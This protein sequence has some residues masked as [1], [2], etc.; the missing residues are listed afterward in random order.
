[1]RRRSDLILVADLVVSLLVA[2]KPPFMSLPSWE[3]ISRAGEVWAAPRRP[4]KSDVALTLYRDA[5][6]WCP[7]CQR[8]WFFMEAKGLRYVT[9]KI[10]LQSDPAEPPKPAFY[11]R[12]VPSGSVPAVAIRDE[13]IPE[14]MDILYRLE[15]EFPEPVMLPKGEEVHAQKLCDHSMAFNTELCDWLHNTQPHLEEVFREE[16]VKRFR[17]LEDALAVRGGPFFLG[18]Q[19]SI[20]DAAYIGFLTRSAHNF[21]YFK[22][23]DISDPSTSPRLA[24]WFNAME[25]LPAYQHTKQDA[26]FEQ[27]IFQSHPERRAF[28]EPWMGLGQGKLVGEPDCRMQPEP[29]KTP[30]KAGGLSAL[31]AASN[32]SERREAVVR[33]LMRKHNGVTIS[34][35]TECHLQAMSAVLAGLMPPSEAVAAVGGSSALVEGPVRQLGELIRTPSDMSSAAAAQVL[36]ALALM[37]DAP[38]NASS[39]T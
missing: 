7:F 1:M 19:P 37:A 18:R 12:L 10:S 13:V 2:I 9:E 28:A 25:Q 15:K 38:A 26:R 24:A 3:M 21:L 11:K 5:N 14:S 39:F 20:V 31:E 23:F 16:A 35:T 32:L 34:E 22:G 30:L 6:S 36:A 33:F 17:W 4:R 8:V 29:P 27:R